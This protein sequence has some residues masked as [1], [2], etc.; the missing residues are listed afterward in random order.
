MRRTLPSSRRRQRTWTTRAFD[1]FSVMPQTTSY[2]R[3]R[4][5]S[6]GAPIET[7]NVASAAG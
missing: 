4:C 1:D 3:S 6:A 5:R 2:V 7:A